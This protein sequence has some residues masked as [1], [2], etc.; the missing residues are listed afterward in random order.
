MAAPAV[1]AAFAITGAVALGW[2]ATLIAADLAAGQADR[3]VLRGDYAAA[4]RLIDRAVG[5]NPL[6]KNYLA[7][8]AQVYHAATSRGPD[9]VEGLQRALEANATVQRRFEATAFDVLDQALLEFELAEAEGTPVE[10][11]LP[12]FEQAVDMD[13]YNILLKTF[14]IDFY[15]S[16]GFED[17]ALGH[18]LEILGWQDQ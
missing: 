4:T 8:Q 17:E 7:Q 16:K 10:A 3:A 18:R 14:V 9:R 11:T 2:A 15:E 1:G 5:L 13:P 12:R 6:M